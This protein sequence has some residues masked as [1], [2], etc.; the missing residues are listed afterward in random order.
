MSQ[1]TDL[2]RKLLNNIRDKHILVVDDA[3]SSRDLVRSTLGKLSYLTSRSLTMGWM[4]W[5]S[6]INTNSIW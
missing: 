3:G 1:K 6:S 5:N 4:L 2:E